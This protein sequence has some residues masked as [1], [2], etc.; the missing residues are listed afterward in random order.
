[1]KR[2]LIFLSTV[3]VPLSFWAELNAGVRINEILFKPSGGVQKIEFFNED[4]VSANI[5]GQWLCMNQSYRSTS[6]TVPPLGFLVIDA[7]ITLNL[8]NQDV[9]YYV[10]SS[11]SNPS[12]VIDYV[13]WG[14]PFFNRTF[15]AV[16]GDK[17]S[18]LSDTIDPASV[19]T[20]QSIQYVGP[21]GSFRKSSSDWIVAAPTL[22]SANPSPGPDINVS[23]TSISYGNV[24]IG[25]GS[26]G[27]IVISNLGD[28]N[29]VLGSL[30]FIGTNAGEFSIAVS[31]SS[32]ITP[33]N[34][35]NTTVRFSPSSSGTKSA[36]LV[37]PSN[38]PDESTVSVS[39]T[40][41]GLAS[42]IDVSP[43]SINYGGVQ[44]G[45]SSNST[46]LIRNLGNA[47]LLLGSLSFTGTNAGEFSIA[48]SPSSTITPGSSTNT[49]VRFS[50]SS[51]GT[52]SATLVIPSNDPDESTVSVSLTGAGL[53][54]DIDVSPTSINYGGV[55]VGS[56]SNSTIL[57][58]NLGN[59][60]LLLGSLSF[61]GTNAGEFSIAVS[62]S[63][64]IT[65]GSS[66]NTTV[67]FSPSSV[68]TKSATLVMP[69][70]DPDE[71]TVSVSL[72]GVG[73]TPDID[74]SPTSIDYGLVL[75]GGSADDTLNIKNLGNA[76]LVLGT[77]SF[78]GTDADEFFI[79]LS[80]SS[81]ITPGNSTNAVVRFSPGSV[82]AKSATLLISSN[83]PD[84]ITIATPLTGVGGELQNIGVLTDTID[85]GDVSTITSFADRELVISNT[86][87]LPLVINTLTITGTDAAAYTLLDTLDGLILPA[88][89]GVDTV[90]IRFEPP[91]AG[92]FTATLNIF[93]NDPDTPIKGVNL[94][95]V[96]VEPDI[97]VTPSTFDFGPVEVDS[98]K[99][100]TLTVSNVGTDTLKIDPSGVFTETPCLDAFL[101]GS[102]VIPPGRL[103][104]IVVQFFP[105]SVAVF[106]DTV[107]VISNDPDG[108]F[109]VPLTGTGVVPLVELTPPDTLVIVDRID[110]TQPTIRNIVVR[111]QGGIGSVLDVVSVTLEDITSDPTATF[112]IDPSSAAIPARLSAG[113]SMNITI[114]FAAVDSADTL[115]PK[116]ARVIITSDDPKGI[117]T[118]I[119]KGT[120]VPAPS[121]KPRVAPASLDFGGVFAGAFK[122]VQLVLGNGPGG[123]TTDPLADTTFVIIETIFSGDLDFSIVVPPP[124]TI[125]FG[126]SATVTVRYSAPDTL[127]PVTNTGTLTFVDTVSN[128]STSIPLQGN[129]GNSYCYSF[130]G[131][132]RFRGA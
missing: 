15:E 75:V 48:V 82:G 94:L 5:G 3:F 16:S 73:L 72:T 27:T 62:P 47:N 121:P 28:D 18:S 113:S 55:Q 49:T 40:G 1:M 52:K 56:S 81:T 131:F 8:S 124:S 115:E 130:C 128:A 84:E 6:G 69:S 103:T 67:R 126:D 74:V 118:V 104:Q 105:D 13:K 63:S 19:P 9:A 24:L 17:W 86:G 91:D 38:D 101:L 61:T 80:P 116:F 120:A 110:D 111:N 97:D 88:Q 114:A 60:N 31:P 117:D 71:S 54:S 36:T 107:T 41:A 108:D 33:G 35:T 12:S 109:R 20:G 58:R 127:F 123:A 79:A 42:D 92:S 2:L 112:S 30:S 122:D 93:S 96:G 98:F 102:G 22:G 39:L 34:S 119:V 100:D 11:F 66:T 90:R 99:V 37:I 129:T 125:A 132:I 23:P 65:P 32:T 76:N 26:N 25:S 57:I 43:T 95:G 29:L 78:T 50:P 106:S 68:G 70:N 59:A 21:D 51:S 87:D 85:F 83:D 77:L 53:A 89:V 7:P 45:S 64:T 10:N 46:I 14:S 44:V 4:L